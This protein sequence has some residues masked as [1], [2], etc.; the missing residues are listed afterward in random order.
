MSGGVRGSWAIRHRLGNSDG[1]WHLW[2]VVLARRDEGEEDDQTAPA[3]RSGVGGGGAD[4]EDAEETEECVVCYDRAID[5]CL[6]PCNHAALCHV[7]A[8]R[9]PN[10]RCP[11]CRAPIREMVQVRARQERGGGGGGGGTSNR[12]YES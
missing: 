6:Q 11:L 12:S 5:T 9:L 1:T 4:A 7:C 8:V 2:P 3:A 10:R